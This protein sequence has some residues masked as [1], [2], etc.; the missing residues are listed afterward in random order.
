MSE[1]ERVQTLEELQKQ[2]NDIYDMLRS[3]P[4]SISTQNLKNRKRD[5]ESKLVE[6]EKAVNTFSRKVVY[7]KESTQ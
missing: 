2:K 1:E 5:L 7:V 6:V 4:L 3:M